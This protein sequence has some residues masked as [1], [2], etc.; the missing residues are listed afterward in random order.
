LVLE[1][2]AFTCAA[3]A[4]HRVALP[5]KVAAIVVVPRLRPLST[6]TLAP[7]AATERDARR[8]Y[9]P[10]VVPDLARERWDQNVD[11]GPET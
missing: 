7:R 8:A 4:T 9:L 2:T 10:V 5:A 11:V 6:R 1:R 3:V